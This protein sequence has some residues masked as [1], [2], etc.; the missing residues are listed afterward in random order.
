M[1]I[2]YSGPIPWLMLREL[3]PPK[4]ASKASFLPKKDK[5]NRDREFQ[6]HQKKGYSAANL[7]FNKGLFMI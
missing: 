1:K 7:C 2:G 3:L 5:Q 4:L 6:G